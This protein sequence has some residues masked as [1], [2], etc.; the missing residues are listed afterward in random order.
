MNLQRQ[1]ILSSI[2]LLV[3]MTAGCNNQPDKSDINS[4]KANSGIPAKDAISTFQIAD[5]FKI[6]MIAS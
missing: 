3:L 4:E 6:E 5:G 2:A 1:L